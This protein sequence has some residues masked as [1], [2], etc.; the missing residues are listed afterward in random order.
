MED[1]V[2][3]LQQ[4]KEGR[5]KERKVGGVRME[6]EEEEEEKPEEGKS[7]WRREGGK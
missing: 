6:R 1:E 3:I 5:G 7:N 4:G 2:R